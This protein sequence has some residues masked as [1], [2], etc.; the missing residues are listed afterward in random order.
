MKIIFA[1]EFGD[2]G[3]D[4]VNRSIMG[5]KPIRKRSRNKR[6]RKERREGGERPFGERLADGFRML[7]ESYPD[8]SL[9]EDFDGELDFEDDE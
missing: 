2:S 8:E 1:S 4:S 7:R 9:N 3:A 5:R 6:A